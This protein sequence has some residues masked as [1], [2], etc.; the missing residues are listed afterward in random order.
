M[1]RRLIESAPAMSRRLIE[2]APHLILGHGAD[3]RVLRLKL[4]DER[5]LL[6]LG[7]LGSM[8]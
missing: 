8:L 7:I 2:S 5:D 4:V 3:A 6:Q 1:S